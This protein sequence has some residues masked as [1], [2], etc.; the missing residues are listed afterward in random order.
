MSVPITPPQHT[1]FVDLFGTRTFV[2]SWQPDGP[3]RAA[4]SIVHGVCE[5]SGRYK[6]VVHHCLRAGIAITTFDLPGHGRTEGRRG[7]VPPF[8]QLMDRIEWLV[9]HTQTRFPDVPQVLLGHSW[10]GSLAL[11]FALRRRPTIDAL[12]A[13][14]PA[15]RLGYQPSAVKLLLGK[16]VYRVWPGLTLPKKGDLT[17]LTR[18]QAA[19]DEFLADPLTHDMVSS[20]LIMD[21]LTTGE[22]AYNHAEQLA[23]PTLLIHGDADRVTCANA[24]RDFAERAGD[25]CDVKIFPGLYHEPHHEPEAD[26]VVA[27]ALQWLQKTVGT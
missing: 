6:T 19:L 13:S 1:E 4:M 17:A 26:E 23:A 7:H 11:N 27:Y 10:G 20:R 25:C 2:Q 9:D 5:H 8:D 3:L 14:A 24:S 18:N 16:L 15:L 22:W 21:L 12:V